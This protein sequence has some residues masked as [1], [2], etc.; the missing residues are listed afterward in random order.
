MYKGLILIAFAIVIFI[1]SHYVAIWSGD[2]VD[3]CCN[4]LCGR[5]PPSFWECSFM[6]SVA[7]IQ[8]MIGCALLIMGLFE[9]IDNIKGTEGH[10]EY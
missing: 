3:P 7:L 4:G 10:N 1:L 8:M 2:F 5:C 6:K 9:I